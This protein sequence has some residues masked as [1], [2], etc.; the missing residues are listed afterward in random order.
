[1]SFLSAA[2]KEELEDLIIKT[3]CKFVDVFFENVDSNKDG[4]IT[5][6]EFIVYCGGNEDMGK[7]I[8]A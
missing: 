5:L 2:Q 3:C 6:E 7:N 1:M 4:K 8:F